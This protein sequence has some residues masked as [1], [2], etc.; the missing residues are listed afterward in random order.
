MTAHR[1]RLALS[2]LVLVAL[3]CTS[4][5]ASAD[6]PSKEACIDAHSRCQDARQQGKLST[7]REL[8]LMCAQAQCPALVQD[9]CA[10]YADDLDRLQ[11][12]LGF[13]ARDG[14]GNDLPDTAVYVDEQLLLMQ[15]DD[16]KAHA[17]DPGRHVVRFSHAGRDELVTVVV[18]AG[19]KARTVVATF[20]ATASKVRTEGRSSPAHS[21]APAKA[22]QPR[23]DRALIIAGAALL[24]TGALVGT[25]GLMRVPDNC[26]LSSHDCAAA[27]GD[28]S[29]A[30][31]ERAVRWSNAGWAS[32]GVGAA[33]LMGGLVWFF[34]SA[35]RPARERDPLVVPDVSPGSA[36]LALRGRL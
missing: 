21:A 22:A 5:A 3:S 19:E 7:A 23:G 17:I 34:R 18:G 10:R 33:V 8:F 32:A 6:E 31:A 26:S 27:P 20:H 12:W 2:V 25:V 24:A 36:G 14:Q 13:A 16:G 1:L 35:K 28:D 15:L 11:P 30:E 4:S 29:F 9:D